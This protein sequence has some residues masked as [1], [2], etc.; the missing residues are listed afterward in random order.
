MITHGTCS[1]CG[2]PVV[3]PDVW[4]SIVPPTPTCQRCGAR[5]KQSYGPVLPMEP[6]PE[7][8]PPDPQ[9]TDGWVPTTASDMMLAKG[10]KLL[11]ESK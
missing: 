8:T 3:T 1:L 10:F 2:G 6:A 4:M 9:T 11:M 7:I 5:L